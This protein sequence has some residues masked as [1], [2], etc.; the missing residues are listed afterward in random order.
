MAKG[1]EKPEP[2]TNAMWGHLASV[3]RPWNLVPAI[4]MLQL[5]R[6]EGHDYA[7][8]LKVLFAGE[9]LSLS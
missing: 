3:E 1:D 7:H 6:N 4:D 5:H 8:G 9:S 2:I